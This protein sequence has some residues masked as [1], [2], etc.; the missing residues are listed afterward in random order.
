MKRKMII[1]D[2]LL[3]IISYLLLAS[4]IVMINLINQ[5]MLKMVSYILL[6]I[7]LFVTIYGVIEVSKDKSYL[8]D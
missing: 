7:S 1:E 8:K 5:P 4:S 6:P 3:T 2:Y